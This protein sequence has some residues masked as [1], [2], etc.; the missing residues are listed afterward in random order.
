MAPDLAGRRTAGRGGRAVVALAV[1]SLLAYGRASA[2]AQ[3]S[4]SL[5]VPQTGEVTFYLALPS[6]TTGLDEAAYRVATP[7]SPQYRHFSSLDNAARQ[8]G[9]TDT[10]ISAVAKSIESL[11]LQFAA[12]PTRL[13]GR[14]TGSTQ[15]WRAALGTSLSGAGSDGVEPVHHLQPPRAYTRRSAASGHRSAPARGT[16]LRSRYRR[17]RPPSGQL[18]GLPLATAA[19]P[20]TAAQPW[21]FNTGT[22]LV[23]NCSSQL[24]QQRRVYTEDQVQT[25][26]GIDTL[27]AHASGTPVITVLDLGG[28]WLSNDLKLAGNASDTPHPSHPD[29]GR[30][31]RHGYRQCRRR[32][33][34]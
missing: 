19:T 20:P 10:Q 1:V 8:F 2:S 3:P 29:P 15:Q 21:P 27:R 14:V 17:G 33:L 25:A 12:D 9:A 23:A 26:Y 13:F 31:C 11:G 18:P 16:G 5:P 24:L 4:V 7:G 6:S 32:D 28:G 34:P 22:P 30:R